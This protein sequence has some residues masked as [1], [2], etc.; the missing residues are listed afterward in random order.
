MVTINYLE[1]GTAVTINLAAHTVST[2]VAGTTGITR[3]A[4]MLSG[5]LGWTAAPLLTVGETVGTG[6][7]AFAP[8]GK[9]DGIAHWKVNATT[10]RLLVNHEASADAGSAYKISD[11]NGGTVSLKGA[12]IS[13]IDINIAS[14]AITSAASAITKIHNRDGTIVDSAA[15][16]ESG[17]LTN[18]CSS[19]LVNGNKFG[20]GRGVADRVYFAG[21]EK[22]VNPG[23][24][25]WALDVAT[26][27]LWALPDFGRGKWENIAQ[28]DTGTTTHVAFLMNSDAVGAPLYLYVGEKRGNGDFLARNG[29]SDGKLYVWKAKA[30]DTTAATFQSGTRAG[31]WVEIAV[32]DAQGY[33]T[34]T[35]LQ[36]E[37][38]ALGAFQ[39][40]RLEDIDR[41]PA[42]VNRFAISTTGSAT[43][44]NGSNTA[45]M[46]LTLTVDF[47]NLLAPTTSIK[48][49]HNAN[50]A[51]GQPIRSPDNLE[52]SADG[53]L[54]VQEDK[55]ADIFATGN[56]NTNESSILRINPDTGAV[57]RIAT[58]NREAVEPYDTD[59]NATTKG[60]WESTG[61][62]DVSAV[63]GKA[64]G[65]FFLTN[66]MAHG[67]EAG[68]LV[69]GGQLLVAGEAR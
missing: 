56:P 12:R 13:S 25:E 30:G 45:G 42:Q 33:K 66:V 58:I 65:T 68:S 1:S 47:T 9:L 67:V 8:I 32:K 41:D 7:A 14:K 29:L 53:W 24:T 6:A 35:E 60:A 49:L 48:V 52:W 44:D 62:I 21:E 50:T 26:G 38:N 15:D 54:Y 59:S 17:G 20:A 40:A 27:E 37:A 57:E 5:K 43:F 64:A 63:F 19:V 34:A 28:V 46:A 10:V 39:F 2:F 16:L 61:I 55:A 36:S 23:G 11:G 22:S 3:E 18:L 69:E 51:P 4:P 31:T